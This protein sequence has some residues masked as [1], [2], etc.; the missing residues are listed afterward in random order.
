[1]DD[2][3]YIYTGYVQGIK[4]GIQQTTKKALKEKIEIAKKFIEYGLPI[5]KVLEITNLT[6]DEIK[7]I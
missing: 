5:E 2:K 7:N 3:D 6:E 4:K 1:M